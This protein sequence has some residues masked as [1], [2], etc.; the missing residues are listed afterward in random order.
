MTDSV[1]FQT[2]ARTIDHLGREQIADVPTAVSELWKNAYDA[3]AQ[4]VALHIH[5]GAEPVA[6]IMD[7]GHGMS[8]EQFLNKWLVVGTESK[9]GNDD[10]PVEMRKGLPI[11]PKQGQKGIGRLSVAALGS[12]VLVIS[13]QKDKPFVACLIDWRLFEN[14]YLLLQ[15]VQ[16][17]VE[18]FDSSTQLAGLIASM[19]DSIV[20]NLSGTSGSESRAA[21]LSGAWAEFDRV[22]REQS[23]FVKTT[24]DEIRFP[25]SIEIDIEKCLAAWEVWSG[26]KDTGTAMIMTGINPALSAWVADSHSS[27]DEVEVIKAS[28][29]RTLSGFSDPYVE[30]EDILSYEVVVHTKN[31][32]RT[33]V[34]R[35]E[36]YGIDYL[37]SLD[38][39]LEGNIDEYG[40]FRGSVRAFGKDQGL[41]ELTPSQMLP[42]SPRDRVGPFSLC[43][44]S[45]EVMSRSSTLSPEIHA[46]VM[47]RADS[48]SGLNIY[49][50]G[51]RVMPY[52]RPE[53]DFFKIEERRQMNAGR[54]FWASRKLFGRIALTREKNPNLRDKAGREGVIDNSA[55]RAIQM[56]VVELLK[57]TARRYFGSASDK[58]EQLIA[59]IQAENDAAALKAKAAR[60]GQLNIFKKTVRD[61]ALLLDAALVKVNK[62]KYDLQAIIDGRNAEALW[63]VASRVEEVQ[64]ERSELRLPPKPRNLGKFED[65]Y[66]DYRSRFASLAEQVDEVKVTWAYEAERLNAKPAIDVARSKLGSNQKFLSDRLSRWRKSIA[67]FLKSE[68]D[69][70]ESAIDKDQKEFYKLTSPLLLD[71]EA[72]RTPLHT[73]LSELDSVRDELV[74]SFS[75]AYDPYIRSLNQLAQGV[76]LDGVFAYA[77]ARTETLEKR[78]EQIQGLAQVGISVEILSHELHSLDRRLESS[79]NAFPVSTKESQQFKVAEQ[80]RRELVDRLRFLSQLQISGG[81]FRQEITG[82]DIESYLRSFFGSLLDASSVT[83]TVTKDFLRATFNEFPSRIYPVFINL[84]NNSLYW[85]ASQKEK[86]VQLSVVGGELVISDTGPGIDADDAENLFE[87][88][89]TRRV[90]GRGVGLYLCKQTLAAGGHQIE[91]VVDG[92]RKVLPGAN[93]AI[94]LRNGLNV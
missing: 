56:L 93:F 90:R 34:G 32:M 27:S 79:M 92:P 68:L 23:L 50:D 29:I 7:D 28:L 36:G 11:R 30:N 43:I 51:L 64:E 37:R 41:I 44:G 82:A 18:E 62:L 61:Q 9:A 48:H 49:R 26:E 38:H 91:Y 66:R 13:K 75:N 15:D 87:L 54:E 78:L 70:M 2:R 71:V 74:L 40:V 31:G 58:R 53:N 14:P 67:D 46:K 88:F 85:V 12:T 55:S 69:R 57:V 60:S 42:T 5:G 81:D 73:A 86:F 80:T 21:R 20:E 22:Q 72:G 52:G 4:R 45:F 1:A 89:F 77:G 25:S 8:R 47:L 19:A 59:E 6:V 24:S 65:K 10:L 33:V 3:Y 17:P 84:M 16:L 35:E 63:L 94:K 76:D 83:L 39:C